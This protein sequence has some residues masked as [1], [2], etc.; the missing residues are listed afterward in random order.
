MTSNKSEGAR[1]DMTEGPDEHIV[2]GCPWKTD[3]EKC[4]CVEA[5]EQPP[6]LLELAEVR[7]ALHPWMVEDTDQWGT[8]MVTLAWPGD[9][10]RAEG[11]GRTADAAR[12]MAA[13]RLHRAGWRP[14]MGT[15]AAAPL[16]EAFELIERKEA[17]NDIAE[18]L[19]PPPPSV[20]ELR[21]VL[22]ARVVVLDAHEVVDGMLVRDAYGDYLLRYGCFAHVAFAVNVRPW[23]AWSQP[24][25]HWPKTGRYDLVAWGLAKETPA[26]ALREAAEKF[27]AVAGVIEGWDPN[28]AIPATATAPASLGRSCRTDFHYADPKAVPYEEPGT[29]LGEPMVIIRC[30]CV[31]GGS[32]VAID[33]KPRVDAPA[34]GTEARPFAEVWPRTDRRDQLLVDLVTPAWKFALVALYLTT[35]R[36]M[37]DEAKR[38]GCVFGYCD[39]RGV[40]QPKASATHVGWT[41]EPG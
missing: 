2:P 28:G 39:G 7:A 23:R 21:R 36:A 40:Q 35:G 13:I 22:L 8:W 19:E 33:C 32:S 38:D 18:K 20:D 15:E 17:V 37:P 10:E 25:M 24:L 6:E 26:E 11:W 9:V 1:I 4:Y 31:C 12:E 16:L 30:R 3:P 34:A 27:E 5:G 41:V 29:I 14:S